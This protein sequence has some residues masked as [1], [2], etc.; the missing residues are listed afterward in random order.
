MSEILLC[1]ASLHCFIFLL[2][3]IPVGAKHPIFW[4]V[5]PILK[6]KLLCIWLKWI[7]TR[8]QIGRTWMLIRIRQ[9][10]TDSTGSGTTKIGQVCQE[11][12]GCNDS[13]IDLLESKIHGYYRYSIS[14]KSTIFEEKADFEKL[15]LSVVFRNISYRYVINSVLCIRNN[16]LRI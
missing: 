7:R 3:V 10:D 5:V 9:N 14:K 4:T 16:F 6:F 12:L 8:I 15:L 1:H 13:R 11:M 2:S